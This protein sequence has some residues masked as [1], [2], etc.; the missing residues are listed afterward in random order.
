MTEPKTCQRCE[1]T[2][3]HP[4]CRGTIP[5]PTGQKGRPIETCCYTCRSSKR[6]RRRKPV[7]VWEPTLV[8]CPAHDERCLFCNGSVLG[9]VRGEGSGNP[10]R[11]RK[12]CCTDCRKGGNEAASPPSKCPACLGAC[13]LCSG[14]VEHGKGHK[15]T[16][17]CNTC[18]DGAY[19]DNLWNNPEKLAEILG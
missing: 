18:R 12:Y 8:K 4:S 15:R 14:M 16:Y 3:D 9:V 7:H 5:P 17:C 10:G 2:C 11:P 13:V 19:L 1:G 6:D